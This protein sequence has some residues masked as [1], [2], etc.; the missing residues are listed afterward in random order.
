MCVPGY[1]VNDFYAVLLFKIICGKKKGRTHIVDLFERRTQYELA[2]KRVEKKIRRI[3]C[4]IL[5]YTFPPQC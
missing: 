3:L 1:T 4:H 2:F 5:F